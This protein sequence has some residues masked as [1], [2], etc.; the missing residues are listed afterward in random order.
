MSTIGSIDVFAAAPT[1]LARVRTAPAAPQAG[2]LQL[3][4]LEWEARTSAAILELIGRLVRET[5]L[6][7]G[8][9]ALANDVQ[10]HLGCTRAAVGLC[11]VPGDACRLM[12]VSGLAELDSRSELT[13]HLEAALNETIL[14]GETTAWPPA[15]DA[16]RHALLAH[17]Q[18]AA[19]AGCAA[20][21][22]A[23]LRTCA[24]DVVGAWALLGAQPLAT[25]PEPRQF[26][27]AASPAVAAALEVLRR[28][29]TGWFRGLQARAAGLRR[30]L[31]GRNLAL[32]LLAGILL[33]C[34]PWPYKVVG[35]CELQPLTR[36][37]VAAPYAG[38]FEKSLVEP[39]DLVTRDQVLGRMDGRELRYELAGVAADQERAAKSRD[40]NLVSGKV[41]AAQIDA[42]ER[43]RF[44]N[45]RRLLET[46][47]DHLDIRSPIDGVVISGD[48]KRSEGVAVTV[49]QSLYEIAPLDRMVVEIAVPDEQILF[50]EAGQ[51]VIIRL[52]AW[53][54]QTWR[55]ELR[56]VQPRSEVRDSENVFLAE[57]L[58]DNADRRLRP[59]MKGT[60]RITTVWRPAAWIALH[61]PWNW[62]ASWFY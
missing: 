51:E 31:A 44:G 47:A 58:L 1:D 52:D 27:N 29:D 28:A 8:C 35:P 24:G 6:A 59:G 7:Q 16:Q 43:E 40:V 38:V 60:A 34:V 57:V 5:S 18:L 37:F 14:R 10:A 20:V 32:V 42:L 26:L 19:A 39:G 50:V 33:A 11:S 2:D 48:L 22:S 15:G 49:G 54:R 62:L 36:R 46:R 12:A 9:A 21:L 61:R 13:R 53:P 3:H 17:R 45:R 23:P 55:G 25:E 30:R 4:R 56:K 41:A